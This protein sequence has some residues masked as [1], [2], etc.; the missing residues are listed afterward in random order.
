MV[1]DTCRVVQAWTLENEEEELNSEE[2]AIETN[3]ILAA[4]SKGD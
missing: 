2:E 4:L 1:V 3:P